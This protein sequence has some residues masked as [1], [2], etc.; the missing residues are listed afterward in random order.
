[1]EQLAPFKP[2]A[3]IVGPG[4]SGDAARPLK[5]S[6]ALADGLAQVADV[7]A[8]LG[9]PVAFE[10]LAARRGSPLPW[11]PDIVRFIDDVG[12]PNVGVLFDMWHSWPEQD[13]HAHIQQYADRIL[14]VH[15]NDVRFDERSNFDRAYPGDERCV[16]PAMVASLIQAGYEGFYELEI[17]SDDGTFGSDFP[18]S[19]WKIPHEEMLATA[20]AKFDRVWAQAQELVAS[21]S[22]AAQSAR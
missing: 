7:G 18:D 12:K 2:M 10:L 17:F 21:D 3:F 4:V 14:G 9:V 15:V 1:M 16:A 6:K 13:L 22:T 19:F 8:S 11:L 20:K 5:A